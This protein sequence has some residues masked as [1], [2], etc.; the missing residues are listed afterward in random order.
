MART[1]NSRRRTESAE[2]TRQSIV[3]AAV[4][5]HGQGITTLSAV[6]EEA[7]VSLPTVNK[8]FPTREDLFA[9]CTDHVADT[10]D[11][12]SLDAL[13]AIDDMPQ[14]IHEVV[15]EA[16]RLNEATL[17][18]SWTGYVLE[19]E[20]PTMAAAMLNYENYLGMMAEVL[21]G[22]WEGSR[23]DVMIRFVRAMLGP[24]TYRAL[25]V[26]NGFDYEDA[27]QHMA[28]TLTFMLGA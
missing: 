10:L 6:A 21:L 5:M 17:G 9:A 18:T 2:H 22:D 11:Y 28:Q 12:P 19:D 25:R 23:R 4:K 7:G 1:Y 13:A 8:Y 26:K 20:S 27:V 15:R 14:R 24:L 3:E 16:Y